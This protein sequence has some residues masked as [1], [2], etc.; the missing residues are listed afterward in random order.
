MQNQPPQVKVMEVP[1]ELEFET[2]EIVEKIVEVER[3]KEVERLIEVIREVPTI[4][5]VPIEVIK[6]VLVP[7]IV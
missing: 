4:E 6:E 2:V 1:I 7:Q 3:I 5:Y